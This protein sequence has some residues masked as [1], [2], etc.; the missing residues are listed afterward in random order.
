[1]LADRLRRLLAY[2]AALGLGHGFSVL[3]RMELARLRKRG[4]VAIRSPVAERSLTLRPRSTDLGVFFQVFVERQYDLRRFRQWRELAARAGA[5]RVAV[6][7]GGANIGLSSLWFH[8]LLPGARIVAVE[9]EPTSFALLRRNVDGIPDITVLQ[10]ALWG[11]RRTVGI[12]DRGQ[13]SWSNRVFGDDDGRP[14]VQVPTVVL[15]E[16]VDDLDPEFLVVKI[17]IEGAEAEVFAGECL[18]LRR[19]DVLII[20]LHD[21]MRP[22]TGTARQVLRKVLERPFDVVLLGEHVI[23]FRREEHPV[24]VAEPHRVVEAGVA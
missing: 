13:S 22:W 11:E 1:M 4:E 16:L 8:D 14:S 6:I 17:D 19:V 7:D 20:E 15:D 18:W 21:W 2:P 10:A 9:P 23:F 24:R 12:S 5:G 3:A